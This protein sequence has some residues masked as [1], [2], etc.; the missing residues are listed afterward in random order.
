MDGLV[1]RLPATVFLSTI[2]SASLVIKSRASVHLPA[3]EKDDAPP[4]FLSGAPVS[5]R[6]IQALLA[7]SGFSLTPAPF[8]RDPSRDPMKTTTAC[9]N[10][11]QLL[12]D[13]RLRSLTQSG[14][15]LPSAPKQSHAEADTHIDQGY[16][17]H[18]FLKETR[19]MAPLRS[20]FSV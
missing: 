19:D 4:R 10:P 18:A 13:T 7:R 16:E 14:G 11:Y 1:S 20:P 3:A 9:C 2:P 5:G 6:C 8:P 12:S 15:R 17:K